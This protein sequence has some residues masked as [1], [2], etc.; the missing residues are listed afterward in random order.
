MQILENIATINYYF[1][2]HPETFKL[3]LE[4]DSRTSEKSA[5]LYGEGYERQLCVEEWQIVD[6]TDL[7]PNPGATKSK[8]WSFW[9]PKIFR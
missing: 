2:F 1:K 7:Y 5:E 4:R 9:F 6:V 3:S 8:V